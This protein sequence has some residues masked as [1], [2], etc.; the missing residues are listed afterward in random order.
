MM[1]FRV[2]AVRA[3]AALRAWGATDQGRVRRTNEDCFRIDLDHG[4]CVVADGMGGHNAGEVAARLTAELV[5]DAVR[6]AAAAGPFGADRSLSA[7][8]TLLRNAVHRANAR[9]LEEA[10]AL[11]DYAGMGTTIVATLV[12]DGVLSVT[13]V[14]DSRLYLFDGQLLRQ[15][16]EDDSWMAGM[17]AADPGADPSVFQRHP[18]RNALTNVIGARAEVYVHLLEVPLQGGEVLLLTTDGVHGVL[19]LDTLNG[20]LSGGLRT[21]LS[22]VAAHLV[23]AALARGSRD[24]CT[25]VVAEYARGG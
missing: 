1:S 5:V 17:L 20:V 22:E 10:A 23:A 9:V 6:G 25:A 13:H 18:L 15:L 11:P 8:G 7:A 24:N 2:E 14:G 16:T 21:G 12:R 19:D 4:L 3:P